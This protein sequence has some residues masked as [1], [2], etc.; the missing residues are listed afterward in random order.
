MPGQGR[1][2]AGHD[3]NC[4]DLLRL[5]FAALVVLSHAYALTDGN[6]GR[7]LLTR[8]FHTISFGEL[9][10]DCFFIISGFLITMSWEREPQPVAFLR[11]R[12]L[13][14]VPGFAVAF[15][16]SVFLVG[17][18][19]APDAMR[20][21]HG[22]HV[23]SEAKDLLMLRMPNTPPTFVGSYYPAVNGPLWTIRFEFMC[24]LLILAMGMTG[25][26][27]GEVPVVALWAISLIAF[28]LFRFSERRGAVTGAIAGGDLVTLLRFVPIFLSGAV[29][30]KTGWHRRRPVWLI[31]LALAVLIAG[32]FNKVTA[33]AALASAGAYL[34]VVFGSALAKP[35]GLT[36]LPDIS[37]GVYLYGWPSQKLVIFS[38]VASAP[39]AVFGLSLAMAVCLACLSWKLVEAPAL[40]LKNSKQPPWRMTKDRSR[41]GPR[42]GRS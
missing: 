11:K 25:A 13:R 9:A 19:G 5:L 14:I 3:N 40:R 23:A 33:E 38:G 28:L 39:L 17:L 15:L 20:Y 8:V 26:L 35:R 4:F 27:R 29:M 41:R 6:D 32:L 37:Y 2:T 21:L 1:E 16:V 30:Y 10:V 31:A 42:N 18:I 22:L 36:K 12:I 7:E 24:Y 34:L